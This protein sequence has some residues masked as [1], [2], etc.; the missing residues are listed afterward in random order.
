MQAKVGIKNQN[1]LVTPCLP[2][3]SWMVDEKQLAKRSDLTYSLFIL[4]LFQGW[5]IILNFICK[6]IFS[7][8]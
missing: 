7:S 1:Y 2:L 6:I 5:E 3:Y 8:S 4:P